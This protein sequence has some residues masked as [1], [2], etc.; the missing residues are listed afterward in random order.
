MAKAQAKTFTMLDRLI[1][2]MSKDIIFLVNFI[3]KF[4][5]NN[6]IHVSSSNSRENVLTGLIG[7]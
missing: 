6:E 2:L 1:G 7:T 3:K 4:Y 5:F